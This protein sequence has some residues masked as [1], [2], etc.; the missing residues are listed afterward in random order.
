MGMVADV[1]VGLDPCGVR[2]T[3]GDVLVEVGT[4]GGEFVGMVVCVSVGVCTL[5][6]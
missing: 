6:W 3:A 4:I 1:V 2:G 5:G